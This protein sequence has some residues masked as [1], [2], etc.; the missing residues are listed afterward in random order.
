M[1]VS[2]IM[3]A[4]N[5]ADYIGLSIQSVLNQTV[6][7]WELLI[8][9]DASTD[10]TVDVAASFQDSRIIYMRSE[11]NLGSA[12]A[13]NLALR[14][15]RGRYVAFLDSDD[16]WEAEKLERQL[17]YMKSTGCTISCTDYVKIDET[18]QVVSS[19]IHGPSEISY[20]V[21]L[22]SNSIACSSAMVD[23]RVHPNLQMPDIK[24]NHDYALWLSL[25]RDGRQ[26]RRLDVPLMRYRV[27]SSSLSRNK[28]ES[29]RYNWQIYREL[30]HLSFL[31]S[32]SCMLSFI[33]RGIRK[34]LK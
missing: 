32:L 16:I 12:G 4:Y 2:I 34:F 3:P 18:S 1:T 28:L 27:H 11:E 10:N 15:A 22:R 5:S 8:A 33:T 30:E 7:D 23:R 14:K 21:L 31:R 9:D 25:L 19:T 20:G 24:L 6:S 13:R 26:A 29:A 17:A